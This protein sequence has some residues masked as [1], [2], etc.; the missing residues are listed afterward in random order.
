MNY[1]ANPLLFQ[2]VML[3]PGN[4]AVI[5]NTSGEPSFV[6]KRG[7]LEVFFGTVP[8]NLM[9]SRSP[10]MCGWSTPQATQRRPCTHADLPGSGIL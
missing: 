2:G 7:A 8:G 6:A 3:V 1:S 4:P 5:W 9:R 10:L